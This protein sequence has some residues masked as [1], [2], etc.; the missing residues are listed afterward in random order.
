MRFY[1]EQND[2]RVQHKHFNKDPW[3]PATGTL[4]LKTMPKETESPEFAEVYAADE[5]ELKALDEFIAY[6]EKCVERMQYVEKN[7][8]AIEEAQSLKDYL[9]EFPNK[10]RSEE[11]G[12]PFWPVH[13]HN[14]GAGVATDVLVLE[15]AGMGMKGGNAINQILANLPN[16][17]AQGY[18]GLR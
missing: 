14:N 2:V 3:G 16:P 1:K 4:C 5:R 18:F 13:P 12:K 15:G 10:D 7:L 6:K 11:R 8:V 17:E 9:K